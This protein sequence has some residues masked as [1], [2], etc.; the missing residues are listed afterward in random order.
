VGGVLSLLE[1]PLPHKAPPSGHTRP[2]ATHMRGAV[3]AFPDQGRSHTYSGREGSISDWTIISVSIYTI[4][5][6]FFGIS[7]QLRFVFFIEKMILFAPCLRR[8]P[9]AAN[10]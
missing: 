4:L 2:R 8:L 3:L 10:S 5:S 1:D 9:L 6:S 7:D